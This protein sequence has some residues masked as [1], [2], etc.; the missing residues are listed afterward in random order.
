ME[1]ASR[2]DRSINIDN[3]VISISLWW[4]Y[5][6]AWSSLRIDW[7]VLSTMFNDV[8]FCVVVSLDKCIYMNQRGSLYTTNKKP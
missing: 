4:R 1:R 6:L 3:I 8:L 2:L 5:C 7:L